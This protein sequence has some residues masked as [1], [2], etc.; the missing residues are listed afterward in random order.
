MIKAAEIERMSL[1]ERLRTME[2]L[3]DSM[4]EESAKLKS[5]AWHKDVINARVA[6]VET[7]KARFLTLSQLRHRLARRSK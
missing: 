6:K 1:T 2:L 3:W 5:P 7:G 4:R